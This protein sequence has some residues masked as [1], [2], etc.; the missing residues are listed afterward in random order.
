MGTASNK[1]KK[2]KKA[3]HNSGARKNGK[4]KKNPEF[5]A[6][7]NQIFVATVPRVLASDFSCKRQYNFLI[8]NSM[9]GL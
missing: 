6:R 9:N 2:Q 7:M 8:N 5:E 4:K 3:E 1:E